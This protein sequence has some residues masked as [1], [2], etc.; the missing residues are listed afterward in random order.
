MKKSL[1]RH[2]L[3]TAITAFGLIPATR[4]IVPAIDYISSNL[5]EIWKAGVFLISSLGGIYSAFKYGR[6]DTPSDE[7][8][9]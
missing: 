2:I 6:N 3:V 5:D 1:I 7:A 8:N 9:N 4:V